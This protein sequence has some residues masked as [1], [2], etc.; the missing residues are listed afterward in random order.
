MK[1][2]RSVIGS[3][4]WLLADTACVFQQNI[5]SISRTGGCSR[6]FVGSFFQTV[7]CFG[8]F[9]ALGIGCSRSRGESVQTSG[10]RP[11]VSDLFPQSF[12]VFHEI[13][14]VLPKSFREIPEAGSVFPKGFHACAGAICNF[15][16]ASREFQKSFCEFPELRRESEKSFRVFPESFRELPETPGKPVFSP[17]PA[18]NAENHSFSIR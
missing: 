17:K 4:A 13:F 12:P 6:R 7:A 16:A 18:E 3:S 10:T 14:G 2:V 1:R 8:G 11:A 9:P 15:P 5:I